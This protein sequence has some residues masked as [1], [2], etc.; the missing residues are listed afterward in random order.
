MLYLPV[1]SAI[2]DQLK[3]NSQL[4]KIRYYRFSLPSSSVRSP[5]V[6]TPWTQSSEFSA[7]TSSCIS[8]E[9]TDYCIGNYCDEHKIVLPILMGI[10]KH[11]SRDAAEL[12]DSLQDAVISQLKADRSLNDVV[13]FAEPRTMKVDSFVEITPDFLGAIMIVDVK[14]LDTPH[15]P[16]LNW[17]ETLLDPEVTE[18]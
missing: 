8:D 13:R 16:D 2:E 14:F 1:I 12:L 17:I 4:A 7:H 11:S 9:I 10:A 6:C 5:F 18:G 3:K 15:I